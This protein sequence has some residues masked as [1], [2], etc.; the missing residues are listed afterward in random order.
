M[1][2]DF[3]GHPVVKSQLRCKNIKIIAHLDIYQC[4]YIVWRIPEF[5]HTNKMFEQ[6]ILR[7]IQG[8]LKTPI[9]LKC[10][11]VALHSC[12]LTDDRNSLVQTINC[13]I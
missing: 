1:V 2:L 5:M 7:H 3:L 6:Q 13:M 12:N 8:D 4:M 10:K 9:A 11:L